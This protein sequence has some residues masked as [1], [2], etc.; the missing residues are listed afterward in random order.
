MATKGFSRQFYDQVLNFIG[1]SYRPS[2][3]SIKSSMV[4]AANNERFASLR[5]MPRSSGNFTMPAARKLSSDSF[6][7][8]IPRGVT[9]PI[10]AIAAC[11]SSFVFALYNKQFLLLSRYV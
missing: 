6:V 10:A 7:L 8:V 11:R 9:P 1:G 3:H 4:C 5:L 2:D